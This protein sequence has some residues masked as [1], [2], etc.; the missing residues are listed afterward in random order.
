MLSRYGLWAAA[1]CIAYYMLK[2]QLLLHPEQTDM[3]FSLV[4]LAFFLNGYFLFR[5][6]DSHT[7]CREEDKDTAHLPIHCL[8]SK[9]E[10]DVL[11]MLLQQKSNKEIASDMCIEMSTL[12]SHI[13]H[14]Y[15]KT[16]VNS[17]K[18]LLIFLAQTN[19]HPDSKTW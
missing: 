9:R 12:K 16:G 4:A 15:K 5:N 19:Y 18:E 2:K 3:A 17:R 14:I 6:T 8:L 7:T 1:G 11:H 13:N 10:L